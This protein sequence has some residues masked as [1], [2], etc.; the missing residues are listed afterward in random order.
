MPGYI[1]TMKV[2]VSCPHQAPAKPGAPNNRVRIGGVPVPMSDVP[3]TIMLCP[4]TMGTAGPK[5]CLTST[6]DPTTLSQR[7]K[8]QGRR[9]IL[10]DS[11]TQLSVVTPGAP[12]SKLDPILKPG[13]TRVRA[14]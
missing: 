8:S 4:L 14:R 10:S 12:P 13:Q 1:V 11:T 2:Q 3:F 5:P 7:V 6:Y 9:L